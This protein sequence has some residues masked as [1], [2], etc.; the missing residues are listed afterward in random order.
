MADPRVL[1]VDV[2]VQ[3]LEFDEWVAARG[4]ALMRFAF[5]VTGSAAA[6]EEAVQV[7]LGRIWP[8]WDRVRES[9]DIDQYVRRAVVN[10]HISAWRRTGRHESPVEAV[11]GE[12]SVDPGERVAVAD[13]V[14]RVCTTLPAR[15]RAAVVLRFY[16]DL[17]Y[18]EIASVLDVTE[19]TARSH[20]HRGLAALRVE[21]ERQENDR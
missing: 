5:L 21:L 19:A 4:S 18:S 14:W 12:A 13:A 11:R 3:A 9:R 10:A 2:M 1:C 7:A 15:Q 16:E 20:V 6:A 8:R 17:D